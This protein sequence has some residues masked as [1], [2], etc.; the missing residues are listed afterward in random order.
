MDSI[1]KDLKFQFQGSKLKEA[2]ES[3]GLTIRELTTELGLN[4]HQTLSKYENNKAIPPSNVLFNLVRILKIPINYFYSE[5]PVID[6]EIPVFF[7]SK[8]NTTVKLKKIHQVRIGW[9]EEI[10]NYL[11]TIIEFPESKLPRIEKKKSTIFTP[12]D[13]E[14]IEKLALDLRVDWGLTNGPITNLTRLFEQKGI[15]VSM[16]NSNDGLIDAC[17]SWDDNRLFIMIGSAL[18]SPSRIKFTLAHELGHY[19]LHY[20]LSKEDFNKKDIYK[21]IEIEANYFASAFLLPAPAFSE[22]LISHTLDY[23][24]IL[25]KR[26]HVSIQSMVYRSKELNLITDYQASYLWKSIAK[27]GWKLVEPLDDELEKEEAKMLK[28]AIELIINHD[29]KSKKYLC[30]EL[31]LNKEDIQNLTRLPKNYFEERVVNEGRALTF[32]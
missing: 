14:E 13:F 28:D 26:W 7:R 16:D 18:S 2:R 17:S 8:A 15:I 1:K 22:E 10:F 31:K 20:H 4:N 21:R 6:A 29:V 25:K 32:R 3:R 19:L 30:E 12:T 27:N 5:K 24:K 9:V 23:Y 11:N